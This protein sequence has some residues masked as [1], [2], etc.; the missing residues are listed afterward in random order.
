MKLRFS[1]PSRTKRAAT[2]AND[3]A[4]PAEPVNGGLRKSLFVVGFFVVLTLVLTYPLSAH[5]ADH[6][7][8]I[9]DSYEYA[10]VLGFGAYQLLH[11]PLHLYSGNIFYP[12]PLSL[13]YSDSTVPSILLG[14][15]VIWLT[16]N[17]ILAHNIL[18]LLTF[19]LGGLGMYLLVSERTH[20]TWAA[21]VAGVLYGFSPYRFDHLAQIP[22]V[23]MQWAPFALWC[24]ERYF[25][26]NRLRWAAG[27]A[28]FCVLQVLVSFYY[29]FILGIGIAIYVVARLLGR[30]RSWLT[31]R[32]LVPFIACC[33]LGAAVAAP[34]VLPYFAVEH[35]FNLQRTLVEATAFSAWPANYLAPTDIM[36]FPLIA[37]LDRLVLHFRPQLQLGAGER[38][39][40]PGLTVVVLAL[41]GLASRRTRVVAPVVMVI[42]GVILSFGPEFHPGSGAALKLPFPMPYT[43]LFEYLPG[44][45]A[46]RVP[47]R[48][49]GLVLMGLAILAGDG[50]AL[51]LGALGERRLTGK[52]VSVGSVL[53]VACLALAV[54]EGVPNLPISPV[55][56]GAAVPPVYAWLAK[57]PLPSPVLELPI[58]EN[59]FR[60]SPR[61]YYSTYDHQPLVDGFRSFIPPGYPSLVA[62][63]STFPSS[64]ATSTLSWLGVRY[65]VV[66]QAEL[67]DA[68]RTR[69]K[70]LPPRLPVVARFGDDVVYQVLPVADVERLDLGVFR[71]T[72][73]A[74]AGQQEQIGVSIQRVDSGQTL[75]FAPGTQQLEFQLDWEGANKT[76]YGEII[77]VPIPASALPS[78]QSFALS[79]RLP[80]TAG[81]YALT[82]TLIDQPNATGRV[83]I[84]NFDVLSAA[85][86]SGSSAASA[87]N[88]KGSGVAGSPIPS[89]I[90]ASLPVTRISGSSN[91]GYMLAWQVSRK[92]SR[93][94]VVFVDVYDAKDQYW[95]YPSGTEQRFSP[96][97]TQPDQIIPEVDNLPL[98][99]NIPPGQYWVEVGLLDPATNQ[100]VPFVGPNGDTVTRVVLGSFWLLPPNVL[101]SGGGSAAPA[102]G[103][104]FGDQIVL[105][106]AQVVG[107]PAPGT[108]LRV[109]LRWSAKAAPT[110]NY[111]AFVHVLD[112]AGKLVAQTDAQPTGGVYPTSAW[113][114]GETV[115]DT[116][117]V[118]M[119]AN[120]PPGPYKI[121]IGLYDLKTLQR[122][123]VKTLGGTPVGDVVTLA[124][125]Q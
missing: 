90:Q 51:G 60:E 88:S 119:P 27:F 118:Q 73:L 56:V 101:P 50:L 111:T 66:H 26:E 72:G 17:P 115:V 113:L 40:Y 29:A 89:L 9:G 103:N 31:P 122:L 100:R 67:S 45:T 52:R 77:A 94:L 6:M 14:A 39:L 92:P 58:D 28:L 22:N 44:F 41:V 48:F 20:S 95:S 108:A 84:S 63:L 78:P 24:F 83:T 65:V 2:P 110:T 121:Q 75:V 49:A 93:P 74:G 97:Q 4:L 11:D 57:Q 79:V 96:T 91:L 12:F 36:R 3:N 68:E 54:V 62:D 112:S 116:M 42:V 80:P 106:A 107:T 70:L 7:R 15:P 5:L 64:Q 85:V 114:P 123:P 33:L 102:S 98:K 82:V 16:D 38:H 87:S 8:D 37:P 76:P 30:D 23:S 47:P 105:D 125:G 1:I 99:P 25:R 55:R 109:N 13:A 34:F 104:V 81:S 32:W 61:S 69:L 35:A 21:L 86:L 120:L 117:I 124:G 71:S 46:L 53:A 43:I 59:A 10:W 18:L 19:G